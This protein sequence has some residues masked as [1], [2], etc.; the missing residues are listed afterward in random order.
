MDLNNLPNIRTELYQSELDFFK[1]NPHVTGMAAEDDSVIL[2]PFSN[3]S[4]EEKNAV[5]MNEIARVIMRKE[6][7]TP[8]FSLTPKQKS[9]FANYGS[10][11]EQKRTVMGRII[12]GDPSAFDVTNE[13]KQIAAKKF[14]FFFDGSFKKQKE[15]NNLQINTIW[16]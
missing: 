8:E 4:E 5:V 15:Q 14:P 16:K 9:A 6:N 12:S 1:Q 3:L 11:D 10:E 13:Q 7:Y 2:N